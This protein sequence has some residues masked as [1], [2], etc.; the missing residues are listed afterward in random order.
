MEL[1]QKASA[2]FEG[3]DI[4]QMLKVL[5]NLYAG[6]VALLLS[7]LPHEERE[8]AIDGAMAMWCEMLREHPALKQAL[9][10]PAEN[11]TVQ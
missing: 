11:E 8:D 5:A 3:R 6:G 10:A 9:A 7:D 4:N 2:L 1:S